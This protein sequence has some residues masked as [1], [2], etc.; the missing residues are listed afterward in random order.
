MPISKRLRYEILHRDNHA[1]RYCGASA[2]D[3]VITID[4][5][6]PVACSAEATS[7]T[8]S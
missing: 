2:P 8:T 1:C 5:V 6:V 4:H 3:A 7:R